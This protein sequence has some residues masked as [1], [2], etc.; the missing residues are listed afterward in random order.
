RW[1][2]WESRYIPETL[3]GDIER[4]RKWDTKLWGDGKCAYGWAER[5][6]A[7]REAQVPRKLREGGK[8]RQAASLRVRPTVLEGG[9]IADGCWDPWSAMP[10]KVV[11][12]VE[13][14]AA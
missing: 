10:Q 11:D 5:G 9:P 13:L 4:A 7:L 1:I 12:N 8:L 14:L 3:P 2:G 6:G